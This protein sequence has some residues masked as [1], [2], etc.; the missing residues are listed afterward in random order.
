MRVVGDVG[1]TNARF[2]LVDADGALQHEQTLACGDFAD[3]GAAL[4]FYLEHAKVGEVTDAAVA[5]ATAVTGDRIKFTNNEWDFSVNDVKSRLGLSR[6]IM[7]NDFTALAMSL[8]HLTAD[9]VRQVGRGRAAANA[10][11]GLIGPGTGLGVSGLVPNG[12]GGWIPLS[13]EGGHV[14]V[15][16]A[17]A[18][19]IELVKIVWD[20]APH[21]SVERLVSGFGLPTLYR[22]VAQL[23]GVAADELENWEISERGVA[24]SC[25]VCRETMDVFCAMLGTAAGNL[26]LTLGARGG[27]YIGGGIVP[28]LGAFFEQS[29][30]RER[31]ENKG[32]FVDYMSAIPTFVIEAK[33]PALVGAAQAFA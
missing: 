17:D 1:G 11:I 13:G 14:T 12:A 3:L 4:A 20:L 26:A 29:K 28:K 5:V 6:L 16:P 21:V 25:P 24:G 18:R 22:A 8:P 9:E 19:E 7:L 31:F 30:F 10:A 33:Y 32:R 27:V 23:Q 15:A 2:A